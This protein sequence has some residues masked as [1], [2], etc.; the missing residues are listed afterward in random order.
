VTAEGVKVLETLLKSRALP[1]ELV[2]LDWG[3]EKYIKSQRLGRGA[4]HRGGTTA[5]CLLLTAHLL[6]PDFFSPW[7]N[8]RQD[9]DHRASF[10]G[11][12]CHRK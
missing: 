12:E 8:S 6:T 11:P 9:F 3:A 1:V 10:G 5:L 2:T 4:T 7:K